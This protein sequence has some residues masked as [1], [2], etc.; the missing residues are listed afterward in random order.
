MYPFFTQMEVE[1]QK[2]LEEERIKSQN[3]ERKKRER[4]ELAH[5]LVT[6]MYPC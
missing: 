4:Y 2:R 6:I 1:R 3:E 5:I